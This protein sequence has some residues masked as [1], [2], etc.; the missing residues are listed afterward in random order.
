MNFLVVQ[1]LLIH[2]FHLHGHKFHI[3]EMGQL[4]DQRSINNTDIEKILKKHNNKLNKKIYNLPPSKD[5]VLVPQ[6]GYVILRF[7]ADNPGEYSTQ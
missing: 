4:L 7:K 1:P 6:S 2:P 3:F 5:T